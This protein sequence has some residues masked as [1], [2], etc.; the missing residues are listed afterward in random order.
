MTAVTDFMIQA[1]VKRMRRR[2]R[3]AKG[4][5]RGGRRERTK[6]QSLRLYL[7]GEYEGRT[8]GIPGRAGALRSEAAVRPEVHREACSGGHSLLHGGE[9]RPALPLNMLER[10]LR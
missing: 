5:S 1:E 3:T 10:R 7:N 9:R 2:A 8:E 6:R 4:T